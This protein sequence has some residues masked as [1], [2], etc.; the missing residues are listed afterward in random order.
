MAVHTVHMHFSYLQMKHI[1]FAEENTNWNIKTTEKLR[2][3]IFK[4]ISR[5]GGLVVSVPASGPTGPGPPLSAVWGA[6]NP[7]CNTV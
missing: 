4:K 3:V 7:H 6:A 1:L 2:K 5:C